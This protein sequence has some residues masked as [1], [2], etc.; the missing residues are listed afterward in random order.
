MRYYAKDILM[1]IERNTDR[2]WQDIADS[3]GKSGPAL[4]RQLRSPEPNLSS[5]IFYK[6]LCAA[7]LTFAGTRTAKELVSK[8]AKARIAKGLTLDAVAYHCGRS[9]WTVGKVLSGQQNPRLSTLL[10]L[11]AVLGVAPTVR[12]VR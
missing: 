10:T 1:D 4:L 12:Y 7:C 5:A 11:C 9:S 6:T 3:L 2:T 8:L